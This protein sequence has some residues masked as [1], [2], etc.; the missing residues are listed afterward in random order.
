M[1]YRT[2]EAAVKALKGESLPNHIDSGFV[3]ADR[4]NLDT[5]EVQDVVYE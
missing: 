1:G 3:W 5:K 2:V 4:A